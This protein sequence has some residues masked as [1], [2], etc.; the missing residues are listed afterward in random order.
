MGGGVEKI[1]IVNDKQQ[2]RHNKTSKHANTSNNTD[3]NNT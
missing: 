3:M 1:A 2:G